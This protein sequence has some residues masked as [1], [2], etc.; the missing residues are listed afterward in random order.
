MTNKEISTESVR[1][2]NAFNKT[3]DKKDKDKLWEEIKELEEKCS[4]PAIDMSTGGGIFC[5]VC[6]K[7]LD[8]T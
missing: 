7:F 1:L 2:R 4:H 5:S 8:M 3:K 6:D